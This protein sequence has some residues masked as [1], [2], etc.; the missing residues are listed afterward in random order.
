VRALVTGAAGFIGRAVARAMADVGHDVI[1]VDAMIEQAHGAGSAAPTDV[2]L[3]D[4]RAP[5]QYDSLLDGVDVVVHQAAMVGAETTPA[6]LPVF[7][8]HNDLATA[9]LLAAMSRR[10]VRCLVLASSMVVYGDGWYVCEEHGRQRPTMRRLADLDA[11]RFDVGCPVCHRAMQWTRVD[12]D[13]ALDPRSGYA[14][15]KAAQEHYARAWG[16]LAGASTVALRY[17]NVYG[18][19]MPKDTQYSGVAA[20]FRSAIESG[21]PP[22]VFEDGEQTRDF[23]HVDDV[24]RANLLA[25]ARVADLAPGEFEPFNICSGRPV[26]IAAVAAS[27]ARGADAGTLRPVV[28]GQYRPGDVRHIVASPERAD[29]VLGFAAQTGPDEGMAELATAPLRSR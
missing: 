23:V 12:E 28:T 5:D 9:Q 24:A 14:A 2:V 26:T 21:A 3:A 4:L 1:G 7:A 10:G 13:A 15:G 18:P 6:D 11:G 19:G 20:V 25:V 8:D 16:R 17:H 27:I 29:R 22:R